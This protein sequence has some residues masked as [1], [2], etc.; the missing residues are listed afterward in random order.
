SWTWADRRRGRFVEILRTLLRFNLTNGLVSLTGN[1][2]LMPVLAGLAGIGVLKAN[3]IAIA[4]CSI[5]NFILSDRFVF[6][7]RESPSRQFSSA[8]SSLGSGR[9][10]QRRP[11]PARSSGIL[12]AG[13]RIQEETTCLKKQH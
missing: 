9:P 2:L 8:G 1:I 4:T 11:V 6:T 12:F 3:L 7:I 10:G 13:C 5:A